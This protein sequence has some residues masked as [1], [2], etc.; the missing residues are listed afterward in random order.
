MAIFSTR[1]KNREDGTKKRRFVKGQIWQN[2]STGE[3]VTTDN[4]DKKSITCRHLDETQKLRRYNKRTIL[5]R[6][7][8]LQATLNSNIVKMAEK[9]N[10][11]ICIFPYDDEYDELYVLF[12]KYELGFSSFIKK[13][14]FHNY[15]CAENGI[16]RFSVNNSVLSALLIHID[17][18]CANAQ[19]M[20]I[21]VE[22]EE[23]SLNAFYTLLMTRKHIDEMQTKYVRRMYATEK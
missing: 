14:I 9:H 15:I 1:T 2:I 10:I 7:F 23:S 8:P 18:I 19:M 21:V 22:K 5:K 13:A 20:D 16:D 6:F 12:D 17:S 11:R 4:M 3:F